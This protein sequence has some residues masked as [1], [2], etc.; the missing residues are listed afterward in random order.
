MKLIV[1]LNGGIGNQMFQYA[2]ARA[3]AQRNSVPLLIDTTQ[4]ERG[5]R[6][7]GLNVFN[8]SS[9]TA[10]PHGLRRAAFRIACSPKPA[11]R[12][13]SRATRKALGFDLIKESR[14]EEHTSEL[15]SP[16]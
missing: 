5:G 14:S 4:C 12:L 9:K 15:Q 7:F 16:M 10:Y 11:V 2:A 13:V 1:R 8:I 6:R 3:L